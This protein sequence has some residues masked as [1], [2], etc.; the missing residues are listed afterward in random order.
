MLQTRL[1]TKE[2]GE[3]IDLASMAQMETGE[4]PTREVGEEAEVEAGSNHSAKEEENS[5]FLA[6]QGTNQEYDWF[7][8]TYPLKQKSETVQNFIQLNAFAENQY[9]KRI[10]VIQC[11]GGDEYKLV[12]RLAIEAD[13]GNPITDAI[14]EVDI[15]DEVNSADSQI[16]Q[17]S[18]DD[19]NATEFDNNITKQSEDTILDYATHPKIQP[20]I[21]QQSTCEASNACIIQTKSKSGIHKPK[22]PYHGLAETYKDTVEP[23]N[24]K[25]ALTMPLRKEAMQKEFQALMSNKTW[26]LVPY[27][28]E[29]NIVDSKWVFK[30]K[31]K[32][33]GTQF[34]IEG[35]KLADPTVFR[36]AI[37]ALQYLTHT[38]PDLEFSANKLSQYMRKSMAGQC[39]FLGETLVS[40][41][42]R[43]QM[44]VSRSSTESEYRALADLVAEIAWIRSL[45]VELKLPLPRKPMMWCDNLSAK[46][47]EFWCLFVWYRGRI[48]CVLFV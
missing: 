12:Q 41:S 5:T 17:Q 28:D 36:Q 29:E 46:A 24:S 10:K 26:T 40:W 19:N 2:T 6:S 44:V 7:T 42:S 45:L 9:N 23:T 20:D 47:G 35:E 38:R 15:S 31:Y 37:G 13:I 27:Q 1:V 16:E 3:T 18:Q 25:D 21:T 48:L 4:A 14:P 11:D 33:D 39:V 30:T 32:S 34:I 22:L 43:K 8:W